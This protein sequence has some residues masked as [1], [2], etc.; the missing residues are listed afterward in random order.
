M[1]GSQGNDVAFCSAE[2]GK[3]PLGNL[4]LGPCNALHENMDRHDKKQAAK[5]DENLS[6]L[7][8]VFRHF[9]AVCR[10]AI[11]HKLHSLTQTERFGSSPQSLRLINAL[12]ASRDGSFRPT[13]VA[14]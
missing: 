11:S 12:I 4:G 8:G 2:L 1:S 6:V 3:V 5:V 7:D 14:A 13:A 9:I 10:Q